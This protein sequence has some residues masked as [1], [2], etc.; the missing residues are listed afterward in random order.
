MQLTEFD[1]LATSFEKKG[2]LDKKELE[3]LIATKG[4]QTKLKTL[5]EGMG[6]VHRSIADSLIQGKKHWVHKTAEWT[7][8]SSKTL[9]KSIGSGVMVSWTCQNW[10]T[11]LLHFGKIPLIFELFY[12]Y[13][14]IKINLFGINGQ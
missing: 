10:A 4:D 12:L 7:V 11:L 1:K 8:E 2:K 3:K 9:G 6:Q 14:T 13:L 5:I